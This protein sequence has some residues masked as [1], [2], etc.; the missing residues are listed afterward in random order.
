MKISFK[1]A[2]T[3][4]VVALIP[5]VLGSAG[6][7]L[8]TK[9]AQT[10]QILNQ[11]ESVASIQKNRLESLLQQNLERLSLIA[12]RTQLR[13][14]LDAFLQSGAS[15]QQD[16]IIKILHDA[17]QSI[18]DI[19]SITVLSPAG[20]VVASTQP[21]RIGLDEGKSAHFISGLQQAHSD[22]VAL[23]AEGELIF[24]LSGPLVLNERSIGVVVIEASA[25]ALTRMLSDYSGLGDTGETLLV[26]KFG[27]DE[28]LYINPLRYDAQAALKRK[29]RIDADHLPLGR[30]LNRFE[31]TAGEV[32]DY[33]GQT[34]IAVAK[35]LAGPDWAL[36]VKIDRAEALHPLDNLFNMTVLGLLV[37]GAAIVVTSAGVARVISGPIVKIASLAER[38][39]MGL[40]DGELAP[41]LASAPS[42]IHS[43]A[44][45]IDRM[46][47]S[48]AEQEAARESARLELIDK[49]RFLD[50]I[51]EN[52]PNMIFV[53]D[54]RE[55]RFVRFNRAG[56]RLLGRSRD[57]MIGRNAFDFYSREEAEHFI[58]SDREVL[59]SGTMQDIQ[60]E[61]IQTRDNVRRILHTRKI[62]I[63]DSTGEPVYLLGISEDITDRKLADEALHIQRDIGL[64][65]TATV[66]SLGLY[67]R[68]LD[69]IL[70]LDGVDSGGIYL[71]NEDSGCL[72]LVAHSG[73]SDAFVRSVAHFEAGSRQHEMLSAGAM[74]HARYEDIAGNMSVEQQQEGLQAVAIVPVRHQ[75]QLVGALNL[76]SHDGHEIPRPVRESLAL[77]GSQIGSAI[78]RMKAEQ[79][80]K[81]NQDNLQTLFDRLDDFLFIVGADGKIIHVN[82]V[83]IQ[84]LG[85]S[86]KEL[87]GQPVLIVHPPDRHAEVLQIVSD[88]LAGSRSTN[89]LPLMAKSGE[90]IPVET[91]ITRG[92]WNHQDV[93]FGISRDVT[94]RERAQRV[95]TE[96]KQNLETEVARRTAELIDTNR[97]LLDAKEV[98]EQAN[99]AKSMFL[100][101]MSHE[102]R[103]PMNAIIGM[104]HL[105]LQ[106]ELD[107]RQRNHIE[108]AH[109]AA[110]N[111][112]GILNDILDFSKI[113][114]G[115]LD[116]E[117]V[118]FHLQEVIGN[119]TNLVGLKAEEKDILVAIDV[120]P[121]IPAL[122]RG[123]PLRLGQVL[124]NLGNNAVKFSEPGGRIT[125]KVRLL[126]QR[127]ERLVLQFSVADTGIGMTAEQIQKLFQPFS[128]ADSSTTRIYGGTGL[129]LIISSKIVGLMHGDISVDSEPGVG[130]TFRFSIEVAAGAG[131]GTAASAAVLNGGDVDT[132]I[133]SLKGS[134]VL[135]VEDNEINRELVSEL[136]ASIGIEIITAN[137]GQQAL[138]VLQQHRVDG[139]LMDCQ[140]PVM[141]G[142]EAT[143]RIREQAQLRDLPVLALTANAMKGDREKALR[144]GMNDHIAK[145]VDPDT[146]FTIMAKWM[147]SANSS[148]SEKP[149]N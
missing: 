37:L 43:L 85:Y 34:V 116:L 131:I 92:R 23:D 72:D 67:E 75:E 145:P 27:N 66:Q 133:A 101:N 120:D 144:A 140:M 40:H 98:A 79:E 19:H 111:L 102:I 20:R 21:S 64:I 6:I 17:R 126:D 130:S 141:D 5:L 42:E 70:R 87:K 57:E 125:L 41:T 15:G 146:M 18:S 65:F 143:R 127:D 25:V 58:A 48:L 138:D 14:S 39:G 12:S 117:E 10:E 4:L 119:F 100:A 113:E 28:I 1:L 56:E 108:K 32:I 61:S 54:A 74:I 45:S 88:I 35:H 121:A 134:Q 128:Q 53:K 103:T 77:I 97:L 94:E 80:L 59:A 110:Q 136:L 86:K 135:L 105:A 91:R 52:I 139:V 60:V 104:T 30:I 11:L 3:F 112:L 51:I 89:P 50:N 36:I 76:A 81:D 44:L 99:R 29:P 129:G 49:E 73:L 149:S 106:S 142:Y 107:S 69:L 24:V 68:V 9:N 118:D 38:I 90:L 96:A 8:Y 114:A 78:L 7:Y 55:L 84:R 93:L 22:L 31:L 122:L 83:V 95:L 148:R 46:K 137:D 115:K 123:D 2:S 71:V 26:G 124:I 47:H 147:N 82:P 16:R 109:A 62:P 63:L 132:A 33:R 13:L